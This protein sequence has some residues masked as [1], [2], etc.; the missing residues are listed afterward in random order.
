[1]TGGEED[2]GPADLFAAVAARGAAR[3][4]QVSIAGAGV[5]GFVQIGPESLIVAGGAIA[6]ANALSRPPD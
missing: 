5:V 6:A 4:W 2:K 3:V 1:M